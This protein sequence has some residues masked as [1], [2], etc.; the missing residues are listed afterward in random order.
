MTRMPYIKQIQCK[1][2]G[3]RY[4]VLKKKCP[5]CLAAELNKIRPKRHRACLKCSIKF[6]VGVAN[7][8]LC[9]TCFATNQRSD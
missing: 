7:K 2:C 9:A 3:A 5:D 6:E 1:W 8:F 4:S